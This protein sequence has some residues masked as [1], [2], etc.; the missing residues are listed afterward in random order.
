MIE[1][2]REIDA[3]VRTCARPATFPRSPLSFS[4]RITLIFFGCILAA[5]SL[6]EIIAPF[7]NAQA[8]V[9]ALCDASFDAVLLT[10]ATT[11]N[12][13]YTNAAFRDLTGYSLDAVR[14]KSPRLLQ[15]AGTDARVLER[16]SVAIK[17]GGNF[18]GKA[19]NY[20]SDGT[21]FIMHWRVVPIKVADTIRYWMAIQREAGSV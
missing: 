4:Q 11:G 7:G 18:E 17:E 15:G 8:F 2:E 19:I 10:D 12:I 5:M 20:K 6:A 16:L 21:A 9:T 3:H 14:G 1:E 13:V